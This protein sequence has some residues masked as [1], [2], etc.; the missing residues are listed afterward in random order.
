MQPRMSKRWVVKEQITSEVGEKLAAYPAFFRQIL[1]A[2]GITTA[3]QAQAYLDCSP[4]TS[5]DP[6]NMKGMREAVSCLLDAIDQEIPTVVYGDYDVDGVTATALMTLVLRQFGAQVRPYIPNRF[7]EGY[8]LNVE[9]LKT[10][11][12]EGIK[13]IVTVDCGIRSP[14]EAKLAEALGIKM[15]ISDHHHPAEELPSACAVICP[16]QDGCEYA[17]KDLSGV[18]L[19]YKIAQALVIARPNA[20]VCAEDYLDLVALGTV[21]DV[22]PLVGENRVL[23]RQGLERMR[24][25]MFYERPGLQALANVARINSRNVTATDVA[26]MLGP[27]LN[28]SGRL[29]T[30]ETSLHLL[31]TMD[32][33]E[34]GRLAQELDDQNRHRQDLTRKT[35]DAATMKAQSSGLG[36]EAQDILFAFDETFNPG[37]VGL[38]ASRLVETYYRPAVVGVFENGMARASCRSIPEF[39]I[40]EALDACRHLMERHGGHALAAG[41]TIKR[42]NLDELMRCLREA[43]R[44]KLAGQDLRPVL[45]ADAEIRLEELRQQ[46]FLSYLDMLQPTGQGNAEALFIT[47]GVKVVDVRFMGAEKQHAK[48]KVEVPGNR[49]VLDVVAFRQAE[50][51]AGIKRGDYIDV[52]YHYERNE[53]NGITT[54]QMNAR[55]FRQSDAVD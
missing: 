16:K 33:N 42:E 49:G 7:D 14:V 37:V 35:Q 40:T 27:R 51:A 8:G 18:G 6:F 23:V 53:F 38:A 41:F 43:A 11:A 47:R 31:M 46:N 36:A 45:R 30:A 54:S 9:A 4:T 20:G 34:A 32:R 12:E 19:A 26:F 5:T 15:V 29:E 22:V 13:L 39:H 28:A 55:D 1:F 10:L 52:M 24:A 21:A 3:E 25:R 48:L 44:D 50:K 17:E 2:R